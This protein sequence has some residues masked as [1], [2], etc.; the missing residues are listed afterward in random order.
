M[1]VLQI[2]TFYNVGSTGKIAKGIHD[3]CSKCGIECVSAYNG[4]LGNVDMQDTIAT[5]SQIDTRLH[6]ALSSLTMYQGRFSYFKTRALM[7][8][9]K[10]FSPDIIHLHNLH[11]NYLN[12]GQLFRYIKKH[13]IRTIWTLH[14]CWSFTGYC[15]YFDMA[16]C[17]KWKIECHNCPQFKPNVKHWCDSSKTM[18]KF[19]KK[20]F[21]GV[22]DMTIVTPSE[23]LAGLVK[24]SFLKDYPVKVINNGIDLNLFKPIESDFRKKYNCENKF[25]LLGVAFWWDKRKGLDVFLELAKR[26]DDRFQIVLVGTND[27]VDSKLPDNIISIHRTEN[28]K[29]LAEIYTVAD[30]FVIPT[31][32]DNFP[33]VNIE[34]IACG[35]PIL[36]YDAG[37]SPEIADET[38][39]SIVPKDD[40]DSLYNEI[41]RIMEEKPY[42][43]EACLERAKNFDM[44][45]AFEKYVELYKEK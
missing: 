36:T 11:G 1:K 10:K 4:G 20:L 17:E 37:G 39:G 35:T 31:R 33:T 16:G 24:Q 28:Q 13:K 2:N 23:W 15:P 22:E 26:L 6:S 25:I 38:C 3:I 32:E 45:A 21:C 41:I 7:K 44:N 34:A 14:D 18:Y 30:L 12:L 8:K 19:K 5:S 43:K 9:V 27:N 42:S 29:Q 40:I